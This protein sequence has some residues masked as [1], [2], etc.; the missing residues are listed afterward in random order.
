VIDEIEQGVF[1]G[2][3]LATVREFMTQ[4]SARGVAVPSSVAGSIN[5]KAVSAA[6]GTIGAK[7]VGGQVR[8][9][10]GER[11]R[12]WALERTDLYA[13]MSPDKLSA[14]YERERDRVAAGA[15]PPPFEPVI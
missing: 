8:L 7:Q 12:V 11:V 3:K 13:L 14:E 4:A 2:R 9:S 5:D 15:T 6:L 1:K 10:K